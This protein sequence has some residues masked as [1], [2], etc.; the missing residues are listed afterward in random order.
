MYI[1]NKEMDRFFVIEFAMQKIHQLDHGPLNNL[2]LIRSFSYLLTWL[3]KAK[4]HHTN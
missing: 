3:L 4:I 2:C 1:I